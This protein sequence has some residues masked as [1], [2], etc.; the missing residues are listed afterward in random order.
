MAKRNVPY[1][2]HPHLKTGRGQYPVKLAGARPCWF[3]GKRVRTGLA[4][5]IDDE[6][7]LCPTHNTSYHIQ[8]LLDIKKEQKEKTLKPRR[9]PAKVSHKVKPAK[10]NTRKSIHA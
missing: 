5:V 4:V 9:R 1:T 2:S 7:S 8:I 3:C 6:H 10:P